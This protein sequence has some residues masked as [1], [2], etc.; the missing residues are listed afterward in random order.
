MKIIGVIPARYKSSRF[1]GKPL[2]DICGKPMI[3][4]V[5]T[6]C[7]KVKEFDQVYVATDDERIREACE[8]NNINVVMT[9]DRH[10]TGTD[11]VGEVARKIKAD[12][13]VNIQGD[14]PLIEPENIR[15]AILPFFEDDSLLVSNLMTQIIDPV[16]VVNFTVPKVITNRENEGVYLT[17]S[18]APYPKG[19]ID[20]S[21]Y[22][23][24]CVYGFRPEAL[25]FY[26]EYGEKYGKGKI[27]AIEDIEILR[28]IENKYRVKFIEVDSDTVAVD[29]LNDLKKVNKMVKN[30]QGN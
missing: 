11:R 8:A 2:A 27:E 13:Y 4:W 28:F 12:L 30:M 10:L 9:S 17:R 19:A 1:P 20:Y 16:D 14:E 22:K 21:Y 5:Y 3:W 6:Q 23:Q 15:K 7:I 26:C 25:K 29:T 24:V 18:T